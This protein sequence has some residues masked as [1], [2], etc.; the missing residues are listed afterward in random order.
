MRRSGQW[1]MAVLTLGLAAC[2]TQAVTTPMAAYPPLDP[3][4]VARGREIYRQNCASCHGVNAEGPPNWATPD[5]D[6]L[7]PAPPH[8]DAGHTWHHSDRVLYE[9]I[10]DGMNDPLRAGSPLRM[11]P[12]GSKLSDADIRA[13]IAYFKSLWSDE[14]RQWQWEQT[15]KDFAPTLTPAP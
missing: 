4:Q 6:G 8:T 12:F 9:S 14:H 11:P 10:R 13:V 7:Y 1:F 2:S 5:P 15:L 3:A